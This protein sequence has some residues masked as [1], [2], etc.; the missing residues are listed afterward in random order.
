MSVSDTSSTEACV[1][2]GGREALI[3][4]ESDDEAENGTALP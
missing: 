1:G 3:V 2:W 4:V